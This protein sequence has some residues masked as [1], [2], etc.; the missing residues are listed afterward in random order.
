M[1]SIA[2]G[3]SNWK[4]KHSNRQRECARFLRL[5]KLP[6]CPRQSLTL[7]QPSTFSKC[8]TYAWLRQ[9]HWRQS[10]AWEAACWW[11]LF[12]WASHCEQAESYVWLFLKG[13]Y[14]V[15]INVRECYYFYRGDN[16]LW[17]KRVIWICTRQGVRQ[18]EF[19]P[20]MARLN[21]TASQASAHMI[22]C[23]RCCHQSCLVWLMTT[24]LGD[25]NC[26]KQETIRFPLFI[27]HTSSGPHGNNLRTLQL[28]SHMAT[29]CARHKNITTFIYYGAPD[30]IHS[31]M[32]AHVFQTINCASSQCVPNN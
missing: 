12:R 13:A 2:T 19:M 11:H 32:H 10:R 27:A 29:I 9:G 5:P 23:L 28:P 3:V 24:P 25:P 16:C 20:E 14:V 7:F 4:G 21:K 17:N 8:L 6:P 26:E 1:A 30:H 22:M 18:V 15:W 31:S